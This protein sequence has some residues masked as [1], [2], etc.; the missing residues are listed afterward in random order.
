VVFEVIMVSSRNDFLQAPPIASS[1]AN[2]LAGINIF[3][4]FI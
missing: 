2:A 3:E 1:N 4:R